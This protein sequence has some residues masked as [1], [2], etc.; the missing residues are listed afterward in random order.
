MDGDQVFIRKAPGYEPLHTVVLTGEVLTP[1][2]YVLDSRRTR[3]TDVIARAGGL[4]AEASVRGVQ[5]IRRGELVAVD[6]E[7]ARARPGSRHDFV[8]EGGDSLHVPKFD[9]TVLVIGGGVAFQ[10]RV[11]YQPGAGLSYYIAQSGGYT[12]TADRDRVSITYQNGQR[13]INQRFLLFR[14][15]PEPRPGSRIEV[16]EVPPAELIPF[17]VMGA[18]TTAAGLLSA[19]ATL[20]LV[21]NQMQN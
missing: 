19:L 1:S 13:A 3:I 11:P 20:L 12:E 9:P 6:L 10:T 17:N 15:S 16:P 2:E 5:L 8:L 18:A 7:E 21:I 4:T 14:R